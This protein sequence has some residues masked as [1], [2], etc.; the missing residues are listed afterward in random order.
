MSITYNITT[1]FGAKDS[2]PS[3]DTNKIIRGSEFTTE[4][5]SIKTAFT[6]AAPAASPTFTGTA[7]FN[8]IT[9]G[10]VNV[11][12]QLNAK[13]PLASPTFTGDATFAG[14]V[15]GVAA[16]TTGGT[17]TLTG[18][19]TIV[20]FDLTASLN[21]ATTSL[22]AGESVTVMFNTTSTITWPTGIKWAGGSA[23]DINTGLTSGQYQV[24]QIWKVGSTHY[25]AYTGELT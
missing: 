17:Y 13:A 4:F 1:N 22:A 24:V 5:T 9:I 3:G 2:L 18:D 8:A 14:I 16:D 20:T 11:Q 19:D 15:E 21:L 7:E 23:P 25:G 6:L 10:G 12:T